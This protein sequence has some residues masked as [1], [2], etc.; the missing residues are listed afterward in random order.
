MAISESLL[1]LTKF[2]TLSSLFW[3]CVTR[4]RGLAPEQETVCRAA[5]NNRGR[6]RPPLPAEYF[7]N[8]I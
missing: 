7:G 8:T 6:L 5:I 4:V 3:L 2:Q 1:E